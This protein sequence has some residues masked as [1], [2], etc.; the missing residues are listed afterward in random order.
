MTEA[1]VAELDETQSEEEEALGAVEGRPAETG[2]V[3]AELACSVMGMSADFSLT[4]AAL[5]S[6]PNVE[7]EV[8]FTLPLSEL[9]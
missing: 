3:D 5:T 4:G 8:S 1:G 7:V 6:P 9:P 2:V